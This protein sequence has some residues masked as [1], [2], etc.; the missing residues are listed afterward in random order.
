MLAPFW[1][2]AYFR[3][4][5]TITIHYATAR[6]A[7]RIRTSRVTTSLSRGAAR[8]KSAMLALKNVSVKSQ[9]IN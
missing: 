5:E 3:A 8:D 9:E 2:T 7:T 4:D 6:R 1:P